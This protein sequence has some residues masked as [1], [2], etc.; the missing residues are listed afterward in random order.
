[1]N[2]KNTIANIGEII[3]GIAIIVFA[4]SGNGFYPPV[5]GEAIG[6]DFVSLLILVLGAWFIYKGIKGFKK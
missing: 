4:V 6:Y 5:S 3:I 2:I 1:M